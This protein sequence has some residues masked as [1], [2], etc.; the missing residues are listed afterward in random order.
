[1]RL[2]R[3]YADERACSNTSIRPPNPLNECEYDWPALRR[4][5]VA[6]PWR[7]RPGRPRMPKGIPRTPAPP[8]LTANDDA[9]LPELKERMGLELVD[10]SREEGR[11]Q[12]LQVSVA[13]I[14]GR[15]EKESRRPGMQDVRIHEVG[16]LGHDRPLLAVGYI[17]DLLVGGSIPG[18][19]VQ[20][21]DGIAS[22]GSEPSGDPAR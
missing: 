12:S 15:D 8:H 11:H 14:P 9:S 16:V 7:S 4:Q 20:G 5:G 17:H 13:D 2:E 22:G 18:G 10:H 6:T 3:D 21:V 19:Q 1:M